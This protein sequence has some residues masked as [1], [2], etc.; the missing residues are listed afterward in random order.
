VNVGSREC[1]ERI[2][3]SEKAILGIEYY[4]AEMVKEG[5]VGTTTLF[6]VL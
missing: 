1:S 4:L 6:G 3:V 2:G 5:P